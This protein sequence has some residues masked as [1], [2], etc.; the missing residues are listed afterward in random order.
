MKFTIGCDPEIFL[1]KNGQPFPAHGI[2]P[3][4]KENPFPTTHGAVQVDGLALEFNT[5]P[6]S[7]QDFGSFNKGIIRQIGCLREMVKGRGLNLSITS[8]QEFSKSVMDSLPDE[9]KIL[10]CDPDWNAYTLER[11]PTPDLTGNEGLR[12]AGGHIHLGYANDIPVDNEEHIAICAEITK[13]LDLHVGL[14]MVLIDRNTKR[15]EIYGKAGAFRPKPYGVEYR[16]PSSAWIKNRDY[17][18]IVFYQVGRTVSEV[19]RG[20]F[21]KDIFGAPTEMGLQDIINNGLAREARQ[22]LLSHLSP[23]SWEYTYIDSLEVEE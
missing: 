13:L 3:G 14:F 21:L 12:S 23:W 19:R 18:K 10:G 20:H 22:N 17:R 5:V 1:K 4:T 16:S 8:T 9:A 15:R 2:I 6:V 7:I 11:N